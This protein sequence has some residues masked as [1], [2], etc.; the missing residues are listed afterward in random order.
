MLG[1]RSPGFVLRQ[2]AEPDN[3]RAALRLP[4]TA[5]KPLDFAR[6]Y[7]LGRGDYPEQCPVRTPA[8]IVAPT[9]FSHHDVFTV[10]EVFCRL[11]Y[12]LA[13]GA[14]NVVDIGSNIGISALYFLTRSPNVRCHLFE[15]DPRNVERLR[16]NLAGYEDRYAL[17]EAAV[18]DTAG[19][20]S[21]GRESFGRYGG[22]GVSAQEQIEVDCLHID[23][24]LRGALQ[25]ADRI[26]LL[27]LDTEGLE[28][29]TVAAI[30]PELL[31]RI[32]E[33]V[34]ETLSPFNP[35]PELF[36]MGYAT[37]TARLTRRR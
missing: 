1:G 24:A 22:V 27:K 21:F 15:P 16:G 11:D 32:D 36:S 23:D 30:D 14:V 13:E 29:R 33:I 10:N 7:Y 28:N 2:L 26:D 12:L 25:S 5:V 19:R 35:A 8:G 6:R 34:F 17:R 31:G 20:V 37:L 9:V 3:Y 18:A 4:F